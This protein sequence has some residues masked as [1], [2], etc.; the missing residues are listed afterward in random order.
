LRYCLP[1][2]KVKQILSYFLETGERSPIVSWE[3]I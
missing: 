2:D 1:F 3:E